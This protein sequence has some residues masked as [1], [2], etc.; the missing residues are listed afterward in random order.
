M[1]RYLIDGEG[2]VW[3]PFDDRLLAELGDPDPDY[4]VI[5]FAVRNLGFIELRVAVPGVSP[6]MPRVPPVP[7]ERKPLLGVVAP[8]IPLVGKEALHSTLIRFRQISV[9]PKA[10]AAAR[11]LLATF[12]PGKIDVIYDTEGQNRLAFTDTAAALAWLESGTLEAASDHVFRD[13][14]VVPRS[15]QALSERRLSALEESDDLLALLF[16]KW[17]MS[18]TRFTQ[19]TSGFM[20][21]FGL[22]DRA[23][24]AQETDSSIVFAHVGPGLTVYDGHEEGWTYKLTGQPISSQ[25]D[26]NFGRYTEAAFRDVLDQRKPAFDHVD[27]VIRDRRGSRRN[28]YDRL[29]LP[30][31]SEAGNRILTTLSYKTA[32]DAIAA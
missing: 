1:N 4:D 30:W 15:L 28:R 13:V 5:A 7:S 3:D 19:E 16:K 22:L 10:L 14:A 31:I 6:A 17:R 26:A 9:Q 32:P 18:G 23:V 20:V 24:I 29:L 2:R 21:R 8:A 25:P 27:A 11:R 12:P